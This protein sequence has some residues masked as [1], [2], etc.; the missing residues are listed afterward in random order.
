VGSAPSTTD[1]G[2]PNELFILGRLPVGLGGAADKSNVT[3][4]GLLKHVSMVEL[5]T[6]F[7]DLW[8]T[9][10]STRGN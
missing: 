3:M 7:I 2:Q 6:T 1:F 8:L 10:R 4:E 9:S 5:S